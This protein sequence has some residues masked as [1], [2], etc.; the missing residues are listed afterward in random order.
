MF[1]HHKHHILFKDVDR[2]ICHQHHYVSCLL[3]W[4]TMRPHSLQSPTASNNSCTDA[5][6]YDDTNLLRIVSRRLPRYL[7][8][9]IVPVV[10]KCTRFSIL[11]MWLKCDDYL[12]LFVKIHKCASAAF[13]LFRLFTTSVKGILSVTHHSDTPE[14]FL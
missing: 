14:G 5:F 3:A 9:Q 4:E 11:T 13:K 6:P 10:G 2:K 8:L 7:S 1:R 12:F